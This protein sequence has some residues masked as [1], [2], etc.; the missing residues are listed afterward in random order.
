MTDPV[1]E[2]ETGRPSMKEIAS[3]IDAM[4]FRRKLIGGVDELDVLKQMEKLQA[5]YRSAYEQQAAYYQAL[6]DE[7]EEELRRLQSS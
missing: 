1:K 6:I 3:F 4:K 5:L 7:R 2:P